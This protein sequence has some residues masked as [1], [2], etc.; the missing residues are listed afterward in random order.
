[1]WCVA[2]SYLEAMSSQ[3]RRQYEAKYSTL[4]FC[5]CQPCMHL[6]V[7]R[8][9]CSVLQILT[10]AEGD[11][12]VPSQELAFARQL[13]ASSLRDLDRTYSQQTPA[14]KR[15]GTEF[16]T[17]VCERVRSL[18]KGHIA[19]H[20]YTLVDESSCLQAGSSPLATSTPESKL[21]S[22]TS[23]TAQAVMTQVWADAQQ[24][25]AA[26]RRAVAQ[27]A[28][29]AAA[30]D[31][32]AANA[33]ATPA[34]A[35]SSAPGAVNAESAK[36][37]VEAEWPTG[38]DLQASVSR[39]A[40][41]HGVNADDSDAA[42]DVAAAAEPVSADTPSPGV[43]DN[44]AQHAASAED[45]QCQVDS[46]HEQ[47][48]ATADG[49]SAVAS[50]NEFEATAVQQQAQPRPGGQRHQ[51]MEVVAQTPSKKWIMAKWALGCEFLHVDDTGA[52]DSA[53]LAAARTNAF[54]M[55]DSHF[56]GMMGV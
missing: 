33:A 43:A 32:A 48:A 17:S 16:V 51:R 37:A 35:A 26:E 46:Q 11:A 14:A 5:T 10:L 52:K 8:S 31:S 22:A 9:C 29:H 7:Q 12:P 28:R 42:D 2:D 3:S 39:V 30:A 4:T 56:P 25:A 18:D 15:T 44:T 27:A 41:E 34:D 49:D 6:F 45:A 40:T 21:V 55:I 54:G 24:H 13:F 20:R 53:A 36:G 47:Q 23:V 38:D 1:M 19:G 50:S